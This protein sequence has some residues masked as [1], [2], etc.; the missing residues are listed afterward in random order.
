MKERENREFWIRQTVL[1]AMSINRYLLY[2]FVLLLQ[3]CFG[4]D[5]IRIPPGP[6]RSKGR[7]SPCP[8]PTGP[9]SGLAA[10]SWLYTC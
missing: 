8:G 4:F 1:P 9:V 10:P 2:C 7:L 5:R 3:G 6:K